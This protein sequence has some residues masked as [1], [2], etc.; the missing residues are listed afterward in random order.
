MAT[1]AC[2]KGGGG[3]GDGGG[4]GSGTAGTDTEEE[5]PP[6]EVELVPQSQSRRMS[7][8]ELDQT[9]AYLVGDLTAPAG[10]F[11]SEDQFTPF[12]NDYQLQQVS[13]T[14]V[15]SMELMAID[16]AQRLV[17]D[18]Q[19][20]GVVVPCV[21]SGAGDTECFREFIESFGRL[22]LRRPLRPEE[23]DAYATLQS[24]ATEQN[25]AVDNDFYTA[26]K[27]VVQAIIQD[28]EFLYRLE[29]GTPTTAEG[30][31]KLDDFEIAARI[32]FLLWGRTPDDALLADA[33]AGRLSDPADRAAVIERVLGDDRTRD[34][35]HRYHAMW[36]GYRGIPHGPE[37]VDAFSRETTALIDRVVFDDQA[38]YLELFT[39]PETYV[40][41]FLADHYGL[42]R[43]AGGE[44]WVPYAEGRAGILSHGSVLAAFSKFTDTSPTQRGILISERLQ[45]IQIPQPPPEVDS[46]NPP[47]NPDDPTACKEDRYLAHQEIPSCAGCHGMMD[48]IGMGLENYDIAGVYRATDDGKPECTISGQGALP[49]VGTFSGPAELAS[50]IIESGQLE[51]CVTEHYLTYAQGRAPTSEEA[52]VVD[53]VY[54]GFAEGDYDFLQMMA[55]YAGDE[56]FGYRREPGT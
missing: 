8:A 38:S 16:V 30:V 35:L 33:E 23:V 37:L 39:S 19:R 24:F 12:D 54:E 36:L 22:A 1:G 41:D 6:E 55:S 29:V 28:P 56:L 48:P 2:Y 25:P 17:D 18:P 14:Y 20:R 13:R 21:P 34:Q 47:G 53:R 46:D 26:V 32:S 45:C 9:L 42:P 4:S 15:E 11:L 27:L 50:R 51:R 49:G 7:Q 31:Y 40:D 5:M 3:D 44:G 10:Y 52:A 43:P